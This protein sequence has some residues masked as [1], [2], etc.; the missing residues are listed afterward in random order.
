VTGLEST[1][2]DQ[3][4]QVLQLQALGPGRLEKLFRVARIELSG[5]TA[6]Y[7][8]DEAGPDK[9]VRVLLNPVDDQGSVIKA[10]GDVTIQ[11]YDLAAPPGANRLAEH[12]F[13]VDV[14]GKYWFSGAMTNHYAFECPWSAAPPLHSQITVRAVFVDYLTG[15]SFTTQRLC[16]VRLAPATQP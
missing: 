5:Y 15:R 1:S 4:K 14:I 13:P 9:G 6:G 16:S 11:L 2:A 10:A 8:G 12:S 7:G 3:Q